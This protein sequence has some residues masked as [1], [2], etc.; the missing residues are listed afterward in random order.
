MDEIHDYMR[1]HRY[2]IHTERSYSDWIRRYI[3]F[4]R[5]KSRDDLQNGEAKI[6]KFLTHLA[7]SEY[8]SPSTQNQVMNALVFR[9]DFRRSCQVRRTI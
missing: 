5:M 1:L 2:S 3:F 4:H 9:M 8:V 6:E 7:I